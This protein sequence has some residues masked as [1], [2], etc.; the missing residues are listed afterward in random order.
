MKQLALGLLLAGVSAAASLAQSP[1]TAKATFLNAEGEA[2]GSARLTETPSGVLISLEL[3]GLAPGH[4]AFHIHAVG[5]CDA[6]AGFE[7]AGSHFE[8]GDH[9]HGFKDAQGPHAGDMPNQFVGADGVLKAEVLNTRVTLGSGE[10]TRRAPL[11]DQDGATLVL[12]A[13]ADD[14]E[15]QPAGKAGSRIACAVIEKT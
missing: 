13:D 5:R 10:A 1:Q 11:F 9:R 8:P 12:H 14:Y 3:S 7:S 4:H 15:S 2:V 6:A